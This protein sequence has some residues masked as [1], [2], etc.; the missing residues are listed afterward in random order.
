[1]NLLQAILIILQWLHDHPEYKSN[2]F[3]VSGIS[4]GGIPVPILTQLISNG[5][6]DGIEPR[7]DLKGYILG[8]PV[9]KVSGILNYRVPFVYGMGLISEELYESLKVSCKGEYKIIDP[10]N[11]VCLKNMQAY[12][13]ASNHI[14]AIFM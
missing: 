2:P 4:Y 8:N 3:Y 1:M 7:I 10:S 14:Y 12:N 11:A 9:T 6:K 13:E 5:N